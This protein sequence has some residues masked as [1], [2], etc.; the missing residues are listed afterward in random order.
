MKKMITLD[1]EKKS[2]KESGDGLEW[3]GYVAGYGNVDHTGDVIEKGAFSDSVGKTVPAFF[4]HD[5]LIGK[6]SVLEE[7]SYG[8]R[9]AGKL[10][11]DNLQD[12]RA[13]NLSQKL[14][15]MMG[16]GDVVGSVAYKMS[17]GARVLKSSTKKNAGETVRVLEK[18]ELIEGS[19]VMRPAND[20]AIITSFKSDEHL[21]ID[22]IEYLSARELEQL[23]KSG[24]KMSNSLAKSV[25]SKLKKSEDSDAR[26]L[27]EILA[28]LKRD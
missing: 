6:M 24:A 11:P 15:W 9:V 27:R 22:N 26:F 7:D 14:R 19:I 18:M 20:N 2:I 10:L 4:E 25:V 1:F 8:L 23:L 16:D 5:F 13:A 17:I 12:S 28:S 21:T 3:T